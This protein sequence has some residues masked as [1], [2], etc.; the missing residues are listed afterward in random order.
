MD[1]DRILKLYMK[2][3]YSIILVFYIIASP[4]WS[5]TLYMGSGETYTNLHSAMAAMSSGDTLIIRDGTYTGSTNVIGT[6][7][8]PPN[9]TANAYTQIRAENPGNVLF[10]GQNTMTMFNGSFTTGMQY[11][12]FY[13]IE[14][15]RGTIAAVYLGGA[16]HIKFQ[17]CGVFDGSNSG[18]GF[19][20]HTC[21]YVLVE[22]S[23]IWGQYFYGINPY[24]CDHLVLRRVVGRLDRSNG[25]WAAVFAVYGCTD[26]EVQNCIA[27]DCDQ[28]S[29]YTVTSENIY[30]F[31]NPN[32]SDG[33]E[34]ANYRGC[35]ALNIQGPTSTYDDLSHAMVISQDCYDYY[36]YDSVF[37]DNS[38]GV[39]DRSSSLEATFQHCLIGDKSSEYWGAG[40]AGSGTITES[41]ILDCTQYGIESTTSDYNC[42]YGNTDNF[43]GSEGEHDICSENANAIN[44]RTNGL[45]YIPR[46]ENGSTLA[47][48]GSGSDRIGPQ[49]LYKIGTT[50]TLWGDTG[51]N[52]TTSDDLWPFPNEDLIK[53]KMAAYT[54][55]DGGGGDPEIIGARGFCATGKQLNGTD[56]ITLT[57]YIWEYLGNAIPSD[58]YGSS[59]VSNSG[60]SGSGV[61]SSGGG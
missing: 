30:G 2:I 3:S 28:T 57:S 33:T 34:G 58:I 61:S 45:L 7:H 46:I 43:S 10:D 56:D 16:N 15:G 54:Y 24:H 41:I 50:G 53:T 48:A 60:V 25:A 11:V 27:I 13:G 44:P 55:D 47:T 31:Y 32:N 40:I 36:I 9:G 52:T 4:L 59:P 29:L 17:R 22:D 18:S 6:N 38:R 20:F 8:L 12:T 37:W 1:I 23:Y 26:V 21:S 39:W 5:A 19:A 42:L 14:W 49:I 51:Y 35:I